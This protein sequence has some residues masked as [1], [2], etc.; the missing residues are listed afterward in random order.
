[1]IIEKEELQTLI[2]HNGK[3]L[4]LDRVIEYNT[5]HSIRAEYD[6]TEN[7]IFYDPVTDGVP[8]WAGF[9]FMAQ[10]ISALTGIRKREKGEKPNIGFILS[11]PFMRMEIPLFKNGSSI[12]VRVNETDCTDM[13]FSFDGAAFLEG[14]KVMEGKLMVVEVSD[15]KFNMLTGGVY[16]R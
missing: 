16:I 4:L 11:V 8:A 13:I 2:P 15:E 12:E 3:M 14:R 6:I 9:E 1:L 7:C 10:A 5:D